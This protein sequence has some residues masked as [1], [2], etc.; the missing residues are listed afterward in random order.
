MTPQCGRSS[1][2]PLGATRA[3]QSSPFSSRQEQSAIVDQRTHP[4][5]TASS[6]RTQLKK[7]KGERKEKKASIFHQTTLF[8]LVQIKASTPTVL[9]VEMALLFLAPPQVEQQSDAAHFF[10]ESRQLAL[11]VHHTASETGGKAEG[12]ERQRAAG[13]KH[14]AHVELFDLVVLRRFLIRF[15]V[16]CFVFCFTD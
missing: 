3:A 7:K 8:Y 2:G 4:E 6:H 11:P 16:V 15:C 1:L 5:S 14:L 10:S 9:Q 12:R 13:P